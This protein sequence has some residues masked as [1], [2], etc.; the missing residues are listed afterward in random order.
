MWY[1]LGLVLA[2]AIGIYI[3]LGSP[4][5]PGRQDRFVP[6]GRARRARRDTTPLDWLKQIKR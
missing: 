1:I 5:L 4:G 2:F 3:G 6:S